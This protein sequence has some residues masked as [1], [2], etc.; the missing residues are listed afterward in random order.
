M[1]RLSDS[2]WWKHGIKIVLVFLFAMTW[3]VYGIASDM[4]S[5]VT[6]RDSKINFLEYRCDREAEQILQMKRRIDDLEL[7]IMRLHGDTPKE[8]WE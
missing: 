3:L 6:I 5:T 8:A 7:A 1:N 2:F 4:D